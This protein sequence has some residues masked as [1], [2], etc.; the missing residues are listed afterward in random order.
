MYAIEHRHRLKTAL[1]ILMALASFAGL[2]GCSS[3]DEAVDP[4]PSY[5][6]TAGTVNALFALNFSTGTSPTTRMSIPNTQADG[7]FRGITDAKLLTYELTGGEN[8][9]DGQ[10]VSTATAATNIFTW[11][12]ISGITA[13]TASKVKTLNLKVGTNTVM[14]YGRANNNSAQTQGKISYNVSTTP[15]DTKFQLQPRLNDEESAE[16]DKYS[17]KTAALVSILDAI[18]GVKIGESPNETTWKSYYNRYKNGET[19]TAL[20]KDLARAYD[21]FYTIQTGEARSGSGSAILRMVSDLMKVATRITNSTN[22]SGAEDGVVAKNTTAKNVAQAIIDKLKGT[23]EPLT[24]GLF[25]YNPTTEVFSFKSA[26]SDLANFPTS[27][28]LPKG[29]A[30]LGHTDSGGFK[31]ETTANFSDDT[32]VK[33]NTTDITKIMWPAELCY[34]GNSPVRCSSVSKEE[35]DYPRT[36]SDWNAENWTDFTNNTHVDN[37]TRAVAMQYPVNYGTALLETTVQYGAANLEDNNYALHSETANIISTSTTSPFQLTGVLVGGQYDLVGWN[38]LRVANQASLCT[39]YDND[40]PKREADTYTGQIPIF[41]A[42][43]AATEPNYTLVFDNYVEGG[44]NQNVVYVCLEFKNNSGT[45]F[46]GKYNLIGKDETFYLIG[47][48]DLS[49]ADPIGDIPTKKATPNVPRVFIQ[50]YKTKA[51]FVIGANSLKYAF[52]TVPDLRASEITLGLAVDLTW[53][54]GPVFEGNDHN[55]IILGGN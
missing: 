5:D 41:G 20:E 42:N 11:E 45:D 43:P 13:S 55:G 44:G 48:L 25:D 26:Q 32:S 22:P 49:S 39:I 17:A 6:P 35:G 24:A 21:N 10:V 50:D 18:I 2:S 52:V 40:I 14:F 19:M 47:R 16:S 51:K 7:S 1:L 29:A 54:T 8:N 23:E 46:Y 34:Y 12:D 9:G 27:F 37:T 38:Y 53:E 31:Y 36:L 4:N 3:S 30:Q 28:N 33:P 15:S